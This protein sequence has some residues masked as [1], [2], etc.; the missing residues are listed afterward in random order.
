MKSALLFCV[1]LASAGFAF[2]QTPPATP[3]A[4]STAPSAASSPHQRESTSTTAKEKP[5]PSS[6]EPS[7]ASTPHQQQVTE[8]ADKAKAKDKMMK[9]CIA[10]Q[11]SVNAMKKD[12]AEKA[13]ADQAKMKAQSE[14]PKEAE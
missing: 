8:T 14:Q 6:P 5:T 10:K 7:A 9:D 11:Q 1:T 12:A 4:D 2:A 3:P 13:C